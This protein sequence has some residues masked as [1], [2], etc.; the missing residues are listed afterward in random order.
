MRCRA[1][2]VLVICFLFPSGPANSQANRANS[3]LTSS[4]AKFVTAFDNLDWDA[5]R[6]SFDDNATV[7]YPRAFP[8]R[9]QGRSEYEPAFKI[10]FEQIRGNKAS[11][12]YMNIQ[13]R[14]L[15][16]QSIGDIAIV[17]FHLDDRPGFINRRTLVWQK[18]VA[19]W[20]IIHL[21][22]SEVSTSAEKH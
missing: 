11:A 20:K 22:A 14:G 12:P 15:L 21:H 3:D 5:F 8:E 10:V 9:A 2:A 7:F 1:T 19:G 4:L 6:L 17:P 13:P 16:I 18:T